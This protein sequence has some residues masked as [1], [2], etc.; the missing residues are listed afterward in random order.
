MPAISKAKQQRQK[1]ALKAHLVLHS[2]HLT[3]SNFDFKERNEQ[4]EDREEEVDDEPDDCFINEENIDD[5]DLQLEHFDDPLL[6]NSTASVA[7]LNTNQVL[8]WTPQSTNQLYSKRC[9]SYNFD[10]QRTNE[11]KRAIKRSLR[12]A[13]E[14]CNPLTSYFQFTSTAPINELKN[15]NNSRKHFRSLDAAINQIDELPFMSNN[16]KQT[17]GIDYS[18]LNPQFEIKRATAVRSF[19]LKLKSFCQSTEEKQDSFSKISTS[20]EIAE[21]MY[22]TQENQNLDYQ[23]RCI[24]SWAN[25]F[26]L[27]GEFPIRLHGQHQKVLPRILDED[28]ASDCLAYLR[29]LKKKELGLLTQLS[30]SQ[31]VRNNIEG[32]NIS[33]PT[34]GRWLH[35]LGFHYGVVRKGIYVDGHERKDVVKYRT[36]FVSIMHELQ[37]R[38]CSFSGVS[39]E[40][41]T[42]PSLRQDETEIV[43]VVHDE[44]TFS[45]NDGKKSVWIQDGNPPLRPKGDGN[46]VM[47]SE[48]LCPCHGRLFNYSDGSNIIMAT[49]IIKPGINRDGWWDNEDLCKQL[50]EKA[51]PSFNYLHPG[52]TA[53]FVFDNSSNHGALAPDALV[54]SRL[55]LSDGFPKDTQKGVDKTRTIPFRD[56]WYLDQQGNRITQKMMNENGIQKGLKSILTERGLFME[57][58]KLNVKELTLLLSDQPDFKEQKGWLQEQVEKHHHQILFFPKFHPEFNFIERYWGLAKQFTRSH[59]DYSWISLEKTVPLAF[60]SIKLSTIRRLADHCFRYMDAYRRDNLT[61]LQVEWAMKK[62]SS[63]R[64]IKNHPIATGQMQFLSDDF[65]RCF[66]D[67]PV[68]TDSINSSDT[69]VDPDSMDTTSS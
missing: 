8:Q 17:V 32:C 47:M 9:A 46:S 61:P 64:R 33:P 26:L 12:E 56:G 52:K 14:S 65:F 57:E 29:S 36:Q 60:D 68:D 34:A 3:N 10:S 39:M 66:T 43:L 6:L 62:Y 41:E 21:I 53:L 55:K 51:I 19:L 35:H 24:R 42:P 45:A 48:F 18:C 22:K 1:A 7:I 27:H 40:I 31:W 20:L 11:R 23:A 15:S 37:K 5:I 69:P 25:F 38:M 50:I 16:R 4:E 28:I 59:C 67:M 63:H 2:M 49:E 13:S 58:Q 54:A 44:T 30:F